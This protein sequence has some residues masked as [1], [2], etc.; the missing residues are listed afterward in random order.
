M[1]RAFPFVALRYIATRGEL[2]QYACVMRCVCKRTVINFSCATLAQ[3]MVALA[4]EDV[5]ETV[6]LRVRCVV[7]QLMVVMT[8]SRSGLDPYKDDD[9]G[10]G[11]IERT[12]ATLNQ[13]PMVILNW[14]GFHLVPFKTQGNLRGSFIWLSDN[15]IFYRV[16]Q[17]ISVL[18]CSACRPSQA[19][20]GTRLECPPS[21]ARVHYQVTHS[22]AISTCARVNVSDRVVLSTGGCSGKPLKSENENEEKQQNRFRE[23]PEGNLSLI[24]I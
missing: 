11:S 4:S 7:K 2:T 18:A 8:M 10:A 14:F 3:A 6:E 15:E 1:A 19:A 12:F 5:I 17:T 23:H 24:H 13:M 21:D 16:L 22:D 9:E 20:N